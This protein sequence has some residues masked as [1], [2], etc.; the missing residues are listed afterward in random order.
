MSF[1]LYFP[2][3]FFFFGLTGCATIFDGDTQLLTFDS[4]PTG[5]EVYVDGVLLGVTPMS[6]SIKRKKGATLTM[7]KEGY[8]DRVMP[9]ATTMNMTF[10]GNLV[11]GGLFGTTTDSATGAINKYEPGQFMVTLQKK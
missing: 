9:M 5:A 6:A 10:L 4:V 3:F 8:V 1:R 2:A 7:K 11:T